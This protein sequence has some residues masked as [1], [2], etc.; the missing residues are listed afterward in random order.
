MRR[1]DFILV[2]HYS[3]PELQLITQDLSVQK[4]EEQAGRKAAQIYLEALFN[5]KV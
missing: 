3:L 4:R 5:K 1:F 2:R